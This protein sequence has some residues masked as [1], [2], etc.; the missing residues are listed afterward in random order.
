MNKKPTIGLI[1]SAV[2]SETRTWPYVGYDYESRAFKLLNILKN[3]LREINFRSEIIYTRDEINNVLNRIGDVD[4]YVIYYL[5]IWLGVT[6]EIVKKGKPTILVDDLY[7][8]SG[9]F[10]IEYGRL[11]RKGYKNI[12]AIAS[13]NVKDI[14]RTIRLLWVIY[15]LKNSK[16]VVVTDREKMW[17]LSLD[18]LG[19]KIKEDYGIDIV[20]YDS[21]KV[22]EQYKSIN[23]EDAEKWKI[24]WMNEASRIVDV[25]EEEI[26]KSA[27][28]YL[29]LKKII[30]KENADAITVDCL[31][32]VYNSKIPA[33]PCL[34]FFQLNNDSLTGTCEA[35]IDSTITMLL[36]RY[37]TER[38][39]FVSDPVIDLSSN[40][41]IYAHCVAASKV[42]GPNDISM[43]YEIWTHAEDRSGASIRVLF[44]LGERVTTVKINLFEKAMSIH[45]GVTVS[46]IEEEKAC[47]TKLAVETDAY[48]ILENWNIKHDFSWHR[49]TVIGDY[50]RDFINV[51]RLLGLEIVEEDK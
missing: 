34:G 42:Y 21:Q 32:L 9:E 1:F 27:K 10:L 3:K 2:P 12:I 35:D 39:S 45:S 40:Q 30:E 5:G 46:N 11:R 17:G 49:V 37:L 15:K 50:R 38:P 33:Y 43:P 26:F 24:K 44:P 22:N 31:H 6:E 36:I 25:D 16:I 23:D 19:Q 4:G 8:G 13:S 14:I 41:V 48:K 18:K 20:F 29:V 7:A 28:M 51:A 47:R